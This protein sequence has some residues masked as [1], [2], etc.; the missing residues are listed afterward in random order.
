MDKQSKSRIV[1]TFN[2]GTAITTLL[3]PREQQVA[4]LRCLPELAGADSITRVEAADQMNI[5]PSR[6]RNLEGQFYRKLA[7]AAAAASHA[8]AAANIIEAEGYEAS[9]AE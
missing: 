1:T 6:V 7:R 9:A 4:E 2:S 8:R 5:S 3:T